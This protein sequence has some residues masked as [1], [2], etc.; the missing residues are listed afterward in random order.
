MRRANC[1]KR[2]FE[3]RT[4]VSIGISLCSTRVR[5]HISDFH[6]KIC[7]TQISHFGIS[8]TYIRPPS[9][10]R[11]ARADD[12][13]AIQAL[14]LSREYYANIW[15][16]NVDRSCV[17]EWLESRAGRRDGVCVCA[18]LTSEQNSPSRLRSVAR[19]AYSPILLCENPVANTNIVHTNASRR[20]ARNRYA[21]RFTSTLHRRHGVYMCVCWC[22]VVQHNP[23]QPPPPQSAHMQ[24]LTKL[25]IWQ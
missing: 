4:L 3:R 2:A 5:V 12:F 23:N 9:P 18:R 11:R 17:S 6:N 15:C 10:K 24:R 16:R 8:N 1:T 14:F 20:P 13:S 22:L 25:T 19:L 21:K 7:I